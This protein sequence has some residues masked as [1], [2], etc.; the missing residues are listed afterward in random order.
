MSM[1]PFH[2]AN[3]RVPQEPHQDRTMAES[4]GID[5]ARYDRTRPR[6]PQELVDWILASTPG[7][8]VLEVGTG[9]GVSAQPFCARGYRVLG[10]E[11]DQRMGEFARNRGFTVEI[12]RFE[13]WDPAGRSFD[14]LIA[15]MTWH[16]IDS[17]VG[18]A[19]AAAVL[20]PSGLL[21]LFWYVHQPPPELA[22]AFAEVY[23]E[24]LPATPFAS[25]PIDP[26]ARYYRILDTAAAG[27]GA[28][29]AFSPT[30]RLRF[31]WQR[32]YTRDQ[33]LDQ[34]PTFGGH[35]ALPGNRLDQLLTGIGSAIDQVGGSFDM[36]YASL[37]IKAA[38][39]M[40]PTAREPR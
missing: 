9:T 12:A 16:W 19:K 39:R 29:R 2:P 31:D 33:W 23:R 36:R 8:E 37:A 35:G 15:G 40:S 26:L 28:T 5:P 38:R 32:S 4:F 22:R 13:E 14:A 7:Y 21:A 27:I 3:R 18:A 34:V 6:Y 30:Q 20:R 11:P 1:E 17:A 25:M 10:I 24:V